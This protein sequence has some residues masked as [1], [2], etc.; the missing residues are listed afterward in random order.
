MT[1]GSGQAS[2]RAV[3]QKFVRKRGV[4]GLFAGLRP[5]LFAVVPFVG[6]QQASYDFMK[7]NLINTGVFAPSVQ[8]FLSCGALA[9]MVA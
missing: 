4:R 8:L 5:T 9:G 3:F 2:F 6:I 7:Q 1:L